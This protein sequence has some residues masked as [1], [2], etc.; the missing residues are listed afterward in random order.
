M[1]CTSERSALSIINATGAEGGIASN[2]TSN[3]TTADVNGNGCDGNSTGA[4]SSDNGPVTVT[5]TVGQQSTF[6]TSLPAETST[7]SP[8]EASSL[9]SSIAT[10][11]AF[12]LVSTVLPSSTSS[13]ATTTDA[14]ESQSGASQAAPTTILLTAA[15]AAASQG[16]TP[17]VNQ[18]AA[19]AATSPAE[20]SASAA[21]SSGSDYGY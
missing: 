18:V 12:A 19:A 15:S 8:D 2:G 13:A 3:S 6:S 10:D 20:S 9:L 1:T 14:P 5:V 16:S 21:G 17:S 11:S 4:A 7:L